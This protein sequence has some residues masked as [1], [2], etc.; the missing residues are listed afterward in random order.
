MAAQFGFGLLGVLAAL[1]AIPIIVVGAALGEAVFI[2]SVV[3][4]ILC[5]RPGRRCP[6]GAERHLPGGAVPLRGERRGAR[7][8]LHRGRPSPQHSCTKEDVGGGWLSRL[9]VD[10]ASVPVVTGNNI[11]A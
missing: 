9:T 3:L 1:G 5:G 10:R 7:R 11:T 2:V 4:A 6:L 8:I